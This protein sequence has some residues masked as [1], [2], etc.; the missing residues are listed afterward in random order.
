MLLRQSSKHCPT[1]REYTC[2]ETK[3]PAALVD[4]E[5]YNCWKWAASA[6]AIQMHVK[7]AEEIEVTN[8]AKGAFR[9]PLELKQEVGFE[10]ELFRNTQPWHSSEPN[11]W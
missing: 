6:V 8:Q 10:G 9:A 11:T 7:L 3:P 1:E 4:L 5:P 2:R